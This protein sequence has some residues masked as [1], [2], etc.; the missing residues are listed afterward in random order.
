MKAGGIRAAAVG[1]VAGFLSGPVAAEPVPLE[2]FA[3]QPIMTGARLSPDGT[4][5][6][7]LSSLKGRYHVVVEQFS[8]VFTR[9]ILAPGKDFDFDWVHW[10][11]DERL[12]LSASFSAQR[13]LVETTETRLFSMNRLA[14]DLKEIIRPAR[15]KEVGSRIAKEHPPAQLQDDVVHWLPNEPDHILVALDADH[16]RAIEVRKVD[17]LSGKYDTVL[18]DFAGQANWLADS[19]GE[20]RLAWE[21]LDDERVLTVLGAD[22]R[23]SELLRKSWLDDDYI[24]AAFTGDGLLVVIGPD[25]NGT[26]VARLLDLESDEFVDTIV[27]HPDVDADWVVTDGYSGAALGVSYTEHLT[28]DHYFDEPWA[29]LMTTINRALPDTTNRIV[30]TSQD[31]QQILIFSSSDANPGSY[32]IWDRDAGGLSHYSDKYSNFSE[33][34]LSPVTPA[35][36]EARDG[37]SIPAYVTVPRGAGDELLP[38]VVL[39]HGGPQ[40]RDTLR[41]DYLRQFIAS[42]GYVVFQPNF[43][44]SS[45]FGAP[46]AEAGLAQWGGKMQQDVTDGVKWLVEQGKVDPERICIVGWSY[47]GY[48]AAIGAIRDPDLYRCAASINGVLNLPRQILDD[49]RYIGGDRWTEHVGLDG[50]RSKTV[51]PYH[52]A[53]TLQVPLLVIQSADDTRVHAVQG[54]G[55]ADRLRKLDKDVEYVEIDFGGH[56]VQNVAGRTTILASLEAFLARHLQ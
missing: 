15:Y 53:D 47:G 20:I 56:F 28:A 35:S 25:E 42:R 5:I 38:A 14:R 34:M 23:W 4:R 13:D 40:A 48:S 22:G 30:N 29:K 6:A 55:M 51:S 8:P 1:L 33:D 18:D 17:I 41:Y 52:L 12:V 21:Q 43:R 44:G 11:N 31:R 37:W 3:Q 46:F 19:T 32:L 54:R 50:E 27:H 24:P 45:G 9:S 26:D 10:A 16:N 49:Q 2:W 39:P 36:F 7:F